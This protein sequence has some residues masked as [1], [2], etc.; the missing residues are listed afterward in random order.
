MKAAV[1]N[2]VG[3]DKLELRDDV[4]TTAPGPAGGPH[5]D[6]GV[7]GL[8][9]RSVRH[10]RNAARAGAGRDRPRGCRR[11]RRDRQRRDLARRR[12]P[13][14]RSRSCRRAGSALKCVS[15][16]SHLCF[17]HTISA[18]TSPRFLVGGNPAFGYAGTRHVR[19]GTGRARRRRGE[20]RRRRAVRDRGADRVRGAD[21]RRRGAQHR[22]GRGGR[23]RRGDRL[24]RGRRLGHPG[25]AARW[26][27]AD[28]RGGPGGREARGGASTSARR[29]RRRRTASPT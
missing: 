6:Q 8:P 21:R 18:F 14:G 1:L 26:R 11:D 22:E 10:G 2:Q 9:Q 13:R 4:T 23:Q 29:T 5:Q 17:V 20:D 7:R 28:R 16:Q 27:G 24:R 3:D 12:R 15:G 25:R 19:R